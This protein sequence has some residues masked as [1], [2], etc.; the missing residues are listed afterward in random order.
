MQWVCTGGEGPQSP[1]SGKTFSSILVLGD[2]ICQGFHPYSHHHGSAF[3]EALVLLA[4][5]PSGKPQPLCWERVLISDVQGWRP[6]GGKLSV[7]AIS[8]F[9]S[10]FQDY[11]VENEPSP[12]YDGPRH[13]TCVLLPKATAHQGSR[14]LLLS[15]CQ[16]MLTRCRPAACLH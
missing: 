4:R 15:L 14:L 1:P 9:L 2:L 12:H 7:T 10:K 13:R 8:S 5:C 11:R 16:G 3:P 6:P